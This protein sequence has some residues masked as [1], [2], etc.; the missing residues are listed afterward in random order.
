VKVLYVGVVEV[1][2]AVP[3]RE[4]GPGIGWLGSVY[5]TVIVSEN[6]EPEV[7]GHIPKTMNSC[8][9]PGFR[10]ADSGWVTDT[11]EEL[12]TFIEEIDT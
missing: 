2:F 11:P 5:A 10:V 6:E 12:V 1:P 7:L 3:D 9:C 4:Y 8:V